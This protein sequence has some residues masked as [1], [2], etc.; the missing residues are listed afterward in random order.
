MREN[1]E[2]KKISELIE[3]LEINDEEDINA[4]YW[5][6]EEPYD[7]IN[8]LISYGKPAVK[9]LSEYLCIKPSSTWSAVYV[10]KIL[11]EIAD[12]EAI[13][14]LIIRLTIFTNENEVIVE[15]ISDALRKFGLTAVDDLITFYGDDFDYP[16]KYYILS[17]INTDISGYDPRIADAFIKALSSQDEEIKRTA[18]K[19]I[20]YNIYDARSHLEPLLED[21]NLRIV[22]AATEALKELRTIEQEWDEKDEYGIDEEEEWDKWWYGEMEHKTIRFLFE[23]FYP[24]LGFNYRAET[25]AAWE[26]NLKILLD[27]DSIYWNEEEYCVRNKKPDNR[28]INFMVNT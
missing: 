9:P 22:E 18:I 24:L 13:I 14:P 6:P 11:G 23:E 5:G 8:E 27:W 3:S 17:K 10:A 21:P 7:A 19:L 12:P 28:V 4:E 20:Q 1:A 26:R 16:E 2:S 15:T 25:E